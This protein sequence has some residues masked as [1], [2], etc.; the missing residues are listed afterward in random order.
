MLYLCL[1]LSFLQLA[2]LFMSTQLP[3]DHDPSAG[4]PGMYST[5]PP[6]TSRL[7]SAPSPVSQ[8]PPRVAV[9][10]DIQSVAG[11][12]SGEY[13]CVYS[14]VNGTLYAGSTS[15]YF[16][17]TFFLFDKK[18]RLAWEDVRQVQKMNQGQ[19]LQVL[20]N[21]DV[22]YTFTG[23]HSPDRAWGVLVSLHN[24]A[25]LDRPAGSR[26]RTSSYSY[27]QRGYKRRNSVPLLSTNSAD[28]DM[29]LRNDDSENTDDGEVDGDD[30]EN[31][32]GVGE[33]GRTSTSTSAIA[34]A[35]ANANAN[36]TRD[37]LDS[38]LNSASRVDR[39]KTSAQKSQKVTQ[40]QASISL[41]PSNI[42][43]STGGPTLTDVEK[44]IGKL[45]LQ[46]IRS[47]HDGVAGKLYAGTDALYFYGRQFF[48]DRRVVLLSWHMVRQVQV[49]QTG[50]LRIIDTDNA[51]VEFLDMETPDKV[52]ASFSSLH[53]E[54]LASCRTVL[55]EQPAVLTNST[56]KGT[57]K[58]M[59]SDPSMSPFF[60]MWTTASSVIEDSAATER[61]TTTA[62]TMDGGSSV[63]QDGSLPGTPVS[64]PEEEWIQAKQ[65]SKYDR[66]V[67]QDHVLTCNLDSYMNMFLCDGAKHSIANF[68]EGRGDSNLTESIWKDGDDGSYSRVIHY[69]HP[70]N[71]PLAPPRAGARKEQSYRRYGDHGLRIE[72]KT[73]VMDVP[74]ADCFYVADRILVEPNQDGDSVSVTMEFSITFVKTTMFKSIISKTTASEFVAFFESMAGYMSRSLGD[75]PVVQNATPVVVKVPTRSSDSLWSNNT[76]VPLLA[77]VLIFQIWIMVELRGV[78]S[79]MRQLQ[80]SVVNGGGQCTV[81]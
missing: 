73:H 61:T 75:R 38:N 33:R 52:W 69:T 21:S 32:D 4:T 22:V 67:V 80:N 10:Q 29:Y 43:S 47:S 42:F 15:L 46:P 53:N 57:L 59:N 41:P 49:I 6:S 17:G 66:M 79:T 65:A 62:T 74:M 2:V 35:I 45:S 8:Q 68:L 39:I 56:R 30:N 36:A 24:D 44:L 76:T 51:A 71:A 16:I 18:L 58:R 11:Y 78:K 9:G 1:L 14:Q 31:G 5:T 13:S 63:S 70:V 26:Q 19:G 64:S 37:E 40:S 77:L 50:G 28:F 72:T 3:S 7:L 55:R 20:T 12:I 34:I 81:D 23:I 48:W 27:T 25:L 54:N 60:S